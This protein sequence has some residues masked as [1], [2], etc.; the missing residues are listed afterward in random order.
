MENSGRQVMKNLIACILVLFLFQG[1]VGPQKSASRSSSNE[2]TSTSTIKLLSNNS[3]RPRSDTDNKKT[4]TG[5]TVNTEIDLAKLTTQ[6]G[7]MIIELDNQAAPKTVANF[8]KL[9]SEGFYNGTTFHR[10]I[11]GFMI[12]GGDPLSK[13]SKERPKHG[14]GGPG[15]T[16]PAE[17]KLPHVRGSVAMARLSD[18]VNPKRNSSGSQ[19]YICVEDA[20]FLDGQYTVFGKVVSGMEV[21]DEIVSQKRDSKD[22]PL[23][24]IPMSIAMV[25]QE[26]EKN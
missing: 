8:K 1:C 9:A 18:Q 23:E 20:P 3:V 14:T 22:N 17:I 21:I 13:N 19:F 26:A 11:P 6:F 25:D 4:S 16:I 15:Y 10:I 5:D 7:D 24:P 12:Q 2:T